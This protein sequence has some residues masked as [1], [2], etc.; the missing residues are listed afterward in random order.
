MKELIAKLQQELEGG[1][2][3]ETVEFKGEFTLLVRKDAI[4]D[5]CRRLKEEFG[6]S[7]LSD[8]GGADRFTDAGRFEVIYNILHLEKSLRLRLK[9]RTEEKNPSVPS[10]TSVWEAA[11]WH[12]REAYDM[13]GIFFENH[14]DLRRM[15]L[16][17]DFKYYPLRKEFPLIG[18]PGSLPLPEKDKF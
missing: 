16:P 18:I 15:Y 8:M 14:P 7:Y 5:V 13:F 11:N 4:A 17:E 9:V 6:F 2:L 1:V 3:L 12:E 10:V